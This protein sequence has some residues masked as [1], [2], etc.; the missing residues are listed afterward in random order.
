LAERILGIGHAHGAT[1]LDLDLRRFGWRGCLDPLPAVQGGGALQPYRAFPRT[2]FP[3]LTTPAGVQLEA[4]EFVHHDVPFAVQQQGTVAGRQQAALHP[5]FPRSS[6]V[7]H[8]W[9]VLPGR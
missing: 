7:A 8:C 6:G 3:L 1:P 9:P 2:V 5:D 4:L